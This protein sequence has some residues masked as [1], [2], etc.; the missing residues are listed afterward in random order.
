[1]ESPPAGK[2]CSEAL[3]LQPE[4]KPQGRPGLAGTPDAPLQ[5]QRWQ[6]CGV[7][8]PYQHGPRRWVWLAPLPLGL[9]LRAS[10]GEAEA[11]CPGSEG[12]W[13]LFLACVASLGPYVNSLGEEYSRYRKTLVG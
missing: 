7:R 2:L 3:Q 13:L 5:A 10:D 1:M 9:R 11:L 4:P 6:F 12:A 8:W